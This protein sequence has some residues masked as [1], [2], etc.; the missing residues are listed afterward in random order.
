[1]TAEGI[2]NNLPEDVTSGTFIYVAI[3]S[4]G[5]PRQLPK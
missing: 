4:E 5:N 3:D 2:N 1:V